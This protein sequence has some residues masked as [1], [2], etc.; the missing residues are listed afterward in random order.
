MLGKFV[1]QLNDI[2]NGPIDIDLPEGMYFLHIKTSKGST[3]KK[4]Q[5]F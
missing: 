4:L 5:I 1:K 3:V 2:D